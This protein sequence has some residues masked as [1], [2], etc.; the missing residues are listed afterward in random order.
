MG[1]GRAIQIRQIVHDSSESGLVPSAERIKLVEW[2]YTY[3]TLL[4]PP[5]ARQ[6]RGTFKQAAGAAKGGDELA[7]AVLAARTISL[8]NRGA[9]AG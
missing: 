2:F 1:K 7:A 3:T 5:L 9:A 4:R 6:P 8:V